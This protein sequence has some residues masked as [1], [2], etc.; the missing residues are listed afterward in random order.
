MRQ[1]TLIFI[2]LTTLYFCGQKQEKKVDYALQVGDIDF[3]SKIDDSNFKLC[4]ETRVLQYYNFGKGLQYKGEKIAISE[5]FKKGLKTKEVIG[6]TG[7]LTIRFIVN[8]NGATGRF[9]IQGMD[10][11]YKEKNF[12]DNI[13]SQV[14]SLTKKLDGWIV[15]EIDGTKYDYY[16]YLALKIENGKLIE[17]MP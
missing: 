4:D 6:E 14:L 2:L 10:N 16:Q 3:N 15:G 5:H 12:G 8:C 9:R 13:S 11:E 1:A 17:V 7:V